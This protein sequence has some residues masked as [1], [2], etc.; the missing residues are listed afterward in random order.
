VNAI[1]EHIQ[2]GQLQEAASLAHTLKGSSGNMGAEALFQQAASMEAACR[3]ND[4]TAALANID[5]LRCVQQEVMAGLL[6]LEE[7][8]SS[9][10]EITSAPQGMDPDALRA[11][12]RQMEGYLDTD[13]GEA[14][15]CLHKLRAS[16]ASASWF[17]ELESALNSFDIEA[18]RRV[19][20]QVYKA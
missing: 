8:E 10:A 4:K 2:Q 11:L 16:S 6:T 17:E 19:V 7:R 12:L 20:Q 14:Q 13:L 15:N 3:A 18:A 5:D 1:E 9:P